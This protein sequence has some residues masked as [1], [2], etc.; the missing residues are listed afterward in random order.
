ML[1][2]NE[3]M[4]TSGNYRKFKID[5]SGK[6]YVHTI[7]ALTGFASENDLL[8]AT[9]ISNLDCADVDGYAT[10]FMAMG[11]DKTLE[12]V[13]SHKELKVY[14]IY[15]DSEGNTKTYTSPELRLRNKE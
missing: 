5:A 7:N 3:A 14:L 2:G 8:S 9:V 13:G 6:K 15:L 1:L 4:A 11:F 10:S 12:F